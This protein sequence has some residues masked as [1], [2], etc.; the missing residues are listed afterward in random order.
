MY[1]KIHIEGD[2]TIV[3]ACDED[4]IGK[5]FRDGV[6]RI[7]VHEEFYRGDSVPEEAFVERLAFATIINLTGN[8][9]VDI[10]IREGYVSPEAVL[11][12]GGVKHAQ[13][14]RM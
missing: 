10:A 1:V 7:T 12:I 4:V 11:E 9:V 5:T 8:G 14:V 3:A 13:A 2:E 6:R